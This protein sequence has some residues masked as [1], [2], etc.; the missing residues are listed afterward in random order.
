MNKMNPSEV[1]NKTISFT[2][3]QTY[4]MDYDSF[5]EMFSNK[6]DKMKCNT[7]VTK[8]QKLLMLWDEMCD[9]NSGENDI[10]LDGACIDYEVFIEPELDS[11]LDTAHNMLF[12][13]E[14]CEKPSVG[15]YG[16]SN[17]PFCEDHKSDCDS[18]DD[19]SDD[20]LPYGKCSIQDCVCDTKQRYDKYGS[21]VEHN[22]T[23]K[24]FCVDHAVEGIR[25]KSIADWDFSQFGIHFDED[26][27]E[28]PEWY[29]SLAGNP[30]CKT[31]DMRLSMSDMMVWLKHPELH[32]YCEDHKSDCEDKP[33][34]E[35]SPCHESDIDDESDDKPCKENCVCQGQEYNTGIRREQYNS[36]ISYEDQQKYKMSVLALDAQRVKREMDGESCD[37]EYSLQFSSPDKFQQNQAEILNIKWDWWCIY[38]NED[39]FM[40]DFLNENDEFYFAVEWSDKRCC[41]EEAITDNWDS[42]G[43]TAEDNTQIVFYEH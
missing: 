5:V 23:K 8:E 37:K 14:K 22:K 24:L 17:T 36:I 19:S 15:T 21:I 16:I 13:C 7:N 6:I 10:D 40:K 43:M 32:H 38:V 2:M 34:K 18:S 4:E 31:C 42:S 25:D 30:K 35:S 9:T 12:I 27:E 26:E 11:F 29:D 28:A 1:M 41:W 39:K 3:T 33:C 20:D